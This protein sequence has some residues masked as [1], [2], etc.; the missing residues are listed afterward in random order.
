MALPQGGIIFGPV[1]NWS[2]S[3]CKLL[4]EFEGEEGGK[5]QRDLRENEEVLRVSDSSSAERAVEILNRAI[6]IQDSTQ[7]EFRAK[8]EDEDIFDSITV[9]PEKLNGSLPI[10]KGRKKKAEVGRIKQQIE[11]L[12]AKMEKMEKEEEDGESENE[13]MRQ[14]AKKGK[15]VKRNGELTLV[16]LAEE[17]GTR[18]V[19]PAIPKSFEEIRINTFGV[20]PPAWNLQDSQKEWLEEGTQATMD[21]VNKDDDT[22]TVPLKEA[23]ETMGGGLADSKYAVRELTEEEVK[24]LTEDNEKE[25]V[26]DQGAYRKRVFE[27][28]SELELVGSIRENAEVLRQIG[29]LK[30]EHRSWRTKKDANL[31]RSIIIMNGDCIEEGLCEDGNREGKGGWRR[32]MDL[33]VEEGHKGKAKAVSEAERHWRVASE[34]KTGILRGLEGELKKVKEQLAL[35]A[36]AMG[37]GT[38]EEQARVKKTISARKGRADEEQRKERELKKIESRKREVEAEKKR[39]EIAQKEAEKVASQAKSVRDS[40]QKAWD[41]CEEELVKLRSRNRSI[42]SEDELIE[43]GNKMK[44][45]KAMKERIEREVKQPLETRVGRSRHV[46]DGEILKSVEVVMG[47]A[48]A[49]DIKG[50]NELEAAVG[51]V[52]MLLRTIAVTQNEKAWTV[53]AKAG[54]GEFRDESTWSVWGVAQEVDP[55]K[56]AGQVGKISVL[57]RTGLL[58]SDP[59]KTDPKFGF[60]LFYSELTRFISLVNRSTPN[61]LFSDNRQASE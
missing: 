50:K 12:E 16:N 40:Q 17:L 13:A 18:P 8:D 24:G 21:W 48:Q 1:M 23:P 25:D 44:E 4:L 19:E 10:P 15:R 2:K 26:L 22:D 5:G 47:H 35:L 51:K 38:A 46:V 49:I 36:V 58:R 31:A 54:L 39:E 6:A 45:A 55:L 53:T 14:R 34:V 9:R 28:R 61:R 32:L 3:G 29:E 42:M 57:H 33:V 11:R 27:I 41:T 56:V 43:L 30:G 59:R 52:N 37:A 20:V 7:M 60:S